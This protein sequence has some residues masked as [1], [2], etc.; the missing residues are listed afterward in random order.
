MDIV[1]K[2]KKALA[3]VATFALFA[4]ST[5][6]ALAQTFNDVSSNAWYFDYVEQL[7]DDG[8]IDAADNYNP[9]EALN[10]AQLAKI[11]ITAIDGLA[12]Y[13]APATPTFDDVPADAWFYD[14]VEAAVQLGIV[15]GYTDASGNLTGLYGPGDTVNRAA[16]TKIL[17]NAFSVPTDLDPASSFPDVTSDAWFHDYVVTAYNQSIVDGY[18]NGY[19]GPADPVTRAQIAKLTVLS[20]NPVER[21]VAGGEGE[22][23]GEGEGSG[24][25][26]VEVSLNDDTAASSTVPKAASSVDLLSFDVTAA[27]DDVEVTQVVITRGGVG[28][29]GDWDALYLYNGAER[30]TSGRT[31]N[32]DTN[33]ATFPV[34]VVVEA[35]T[36]LELTL[37]GDMA[38]AA[39]A[40][41]QHYFYVA[42]AAD[43]STNALSVSGDFPVAGNTFTTGSVSVET[44]TVT[45][46]STPT[47]PQ[48]GAQDVEIAAFKLQAGSTND[49]ALHQITVTQNGSLSSA[50]MLNLRLLRG[51]DEVATTAGFNGDLATFV[52]DTPYVIAKGQNKSFYIRADIDGGRTSD[53]IELYLDE[54]TDLVAI[55]QQY[56]FGAVISN[57]S[58]TIA[59]VTAINLKGGKVTL[60]DNG[61][62]ATQ[63]ASNSTNIPL[64]DLSLTVDRDLTVKNTDVTITVTDGSSNAPD[65]D[66]GN[67]GTIDAVPVLGG[68]CAA[69]EYDLDTAA[70]QADLTVSDM[71]QI[72]STYMRVVTNDGSTNNGGLCVYSDDDLT[73]LAGT[74]TWDEVNVY[75]YLKN[76]K[77]IDTDSG[78]TLAGP[79]TYASQGTEN[80]GGT[81][82]TYT[83]VF[84]EDFDLTGGDAR[85]MAVWVDTDI[86][87]PAGYQVATTIDYSTNASYI[88]DMDANEYVAQSDIVGSP[89]TSNSMTVAANS[90]TVTKASTPTSQTYIKGEDVVPS[91]GLAMKAG[92]AGPVKLK[93]LTVRVYGDDD[94]AFNDGGG[95]AT[96][97]VAANNYVSSV[98]LYDGDDVVAGP[99]SIELVDTGSTGAYTPEADYYKAV[100]EDLNLEI[101]AGATKTY[102]AK[103]ALL[104][105]MSIQTYVALDVDPDDDILAEDSDDN[106]ITAGGT[107]SLNLAGTPNPLI[108]IGT[109][110]ILSAYAEGNPDA[111]ILVGGS[112]EVLVAKYRFNSLQEGFSVN[113]LTVMND[114]TTAFGTA[115]DTNSVTNVNIKYPDVNGVTQEKSGTLSNGIITLSKL[116]MY[117]PKDENVYVEIYADVNDKSGATEAISGK[118]FRLGIQETG[119]TISTFEAVGESSSTSVYS[120][121]VNS[122]TTVNGFVVRT[123]KPT[124]STSTLSSTKLVDGTRDLYS[125][126][127]TSDSAGSVDIARMV[128]DITTS[129]GVSVTSF[130]LFENGGSPMSNVAFSPATAAA[131]TT[132][133]II[134]TFDSTESVDGTTNYKLVGTVSGTGTGDT[135]VI[136]LAD[137]DESTTV[138]GKTTNTN[139]NTALLIDGTAATGLFSGTTST[140]GTD[141]LDEVGTALNFIWSDKSADGHS[142][143]PTVGSGSYDWTN[144]YLLDITSL[145]DITLAENN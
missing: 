124:F 56:G 110:G 143:N 111:D 15:S 78:S 140:G 118:V 131:G 38:T 122:S 8:V 94:G 44:L 128:F 48:I 76:V 100:F 37:V 17:V 5:S 49:V 113:K 31:L 88:K 52:L 81:N 144:G 114:N 53:T 59:G 104:N 129:P 4:T 62:A 71:I 50:K 27:D 125:L 41:N 123:T 67:T 10:R 138:A 47:S 102:V 9:A 83:K 136:G 2:L 80:G 96:G 137:G 57:S 115:E 92:D 84:T 32:S 82:T 72:G 79:L 7:V 16:A 139:I 29:V 69:T 60:T 119:N 46:G 103:V 24:E 36:T 54:N 93:R 42:S 73:A 108:T 86:N 145:N 74:E 90:L 120:P 97:D 33:T 126:N 23:E 91:I 20:Q 26:E 61:P 64:L 51:N 116:G 68:G 127:V 28:T 6:V 34:D 21:V 35:G 106:T 12:G 66:S 133:H 65:W 121:T 101:E 117:V 25:G 18:D 109:S 58:Y 99:E 77:V 85:H 105:G 142:F 132:T 70:H 89:L 3:I 98:T 43:I 55:D 39:S 30:L 130:E 141:Y 40:N 134:V 135:V 11:A 107:A 13:E 112:D 63:I 22:G 87:L 14:Y 95:A 45:A 75:S 19:F 1:L